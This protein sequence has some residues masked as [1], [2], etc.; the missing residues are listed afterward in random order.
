MIVIVTLIVDLR[1]S[2]YAPSNGYI[3]LHFRTWVL[4]GIPGEQHSVE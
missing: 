2:D 4:D 3:V 1:P